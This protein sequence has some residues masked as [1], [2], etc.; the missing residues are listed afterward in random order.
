M[1]RKGASSFKDQAVLTYTIIFLKFKLF[2]L[3]LWHRNKG[4]EKNSALAFGLCIIFVST[5]IATPSHYK[6][7]LIGT[8]GYVIMIM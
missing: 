5:F 3:T 6:F 1:N 7:N 2:N 4:L 8:V